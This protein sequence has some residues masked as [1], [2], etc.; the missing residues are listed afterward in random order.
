MAA[1]LGRRFEAMV[2]YSRDVSRS[3]NV[4]VPLI[5]GDPKSPVSALLTTAL[6]IV[7]PAGDPPAP[8]TATPARSRLSRRPKAQPEMAV[9]SAPV[10]APA[11]VPAPMASPPAL[12][13]PVIAAAAAPPSV[14]VEPEPLPVVPVATPPDEESRDD[15]PPAID[16]SLPRYRHRS[17]TGPARHGGRCRRSPERLIGGPCRGRAPPRPLLASEPDQTS[18]RAEVRVLEMRAPPAVAVFLGGFAAP[19]RPCPGRTFPW[20]NAPP[21]DMAPLVPGTSP[22]ATAK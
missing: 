12:P 15:G 6:S 13:V 22:V 11:P 19:C 1:Q 3:I 18:R 4:G 7:L 16:L 17:A 21:I 9:P 2:P 14:P 8:A 10:A 5:V 20:L